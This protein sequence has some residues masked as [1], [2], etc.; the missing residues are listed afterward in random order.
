MTFLRSRRRSSR[1]SVRASTRKWPPPHRGQ[2]R[3]RNADCALGARRPAR[4][5]RAVPLPRRL[6]L[7]ASLVLAATATATAAPAGAA[8]T[9]R[10]ASGTTPAAIQTAVDQFRTDLGPNNETGGPALDG[11]REIDWD[12]VPDSQADPN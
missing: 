9:V 10:Q 12:G 3:R 7:L 8:V 5:I 1:S 4:T 6:L 2:A 11:R